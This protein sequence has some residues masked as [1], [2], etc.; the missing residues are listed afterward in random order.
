MFLKQH[1][2]MLYLHRTYQETGTGV[3][4][5]RKFRNF[6][7]VSKEISEKLRQSHKKFKKKLNLHKTHKYMFFPFFYISRRKY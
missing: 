6:K 4:L 5:F 7:T 3:I 2:V 1:T